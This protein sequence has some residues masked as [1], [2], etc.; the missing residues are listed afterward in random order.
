WDQRTAAVVGQW[1]ADPWLLNTPGGAIDLRTG[2]LRTGRREDYCTKITTIA[3]GG[4]CP[5]WL[6]FLARIT[7]GDVE[8]QAFLMR[9]VGYCLTGSVREECLF[10]L[11]GLGANG[12]TKFVGAVTGMLG[13]YA[14]TAPIE[15]FI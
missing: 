2:E 12:K 6:G 3:P 5:L 1:D 15:T 9:V 4:E 11:Y 7:D 10:F 8:L 13:D 14:K